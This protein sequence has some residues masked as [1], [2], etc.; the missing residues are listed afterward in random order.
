VGQKLE[1]N[2][3]GNIKPCG[4]IFP[5]ERE[6][7][8]SKDY[9][10]TSSPKPSKSRETAGKSTR[11]YCTQYTGRWSIIENAFDGNIGNSA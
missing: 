8:R 7:G 11:V 10:G 4:N 9:E 6:D 1:I 3:I 5:R 2:E